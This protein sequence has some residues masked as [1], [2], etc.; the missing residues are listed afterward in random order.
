MSEP[1]SDATADDLDPD[2]VDPDA[3]VIARPP[4]LYLDEAARLRLERQMDRAPEGTVGIVAPRVAIPP[5]SSARTAAERAA[6]TPLDELTEVTDLDIDGA[7]L[8]RAGVDFELTPTR[9]QVARGP[10]LVDR[11]AATFDPWRPLGAGE[12]A[13]PT[14]RPPFPWRPVVL[15]LGLEPDLDLAEAARGLANALLDREVEARLALP[16]AP[17]GSY[18]ARGPVDPWPRPSKCSIPTS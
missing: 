6:M 2:A 8:L 12:A 3:P 16:E 17:E 1:S 15:M 14:G 4:E 11:G 13:D 18:L 5:G 7:V 9:V 10:L